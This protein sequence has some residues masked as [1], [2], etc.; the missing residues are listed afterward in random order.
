MVKRAAAAGEAAI[1]AIRNA[2]ATQNKHLNQMRK[3]KAARPDDISKAS[4][5]LE[6]TIE[7]ALA[8]AKKT[9]D[10]AKKMLESG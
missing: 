8:E 9:V 1:T 6:K 7:K 3:T 2:R 10:A 5:R 4:D